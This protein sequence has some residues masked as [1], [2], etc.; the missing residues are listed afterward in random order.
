MADVI[1]IV[2]KGESGYGPIDEAYTEK[3][4]IDREAIRYEYK[5]MT[6]S[7]SVRKWSYRTNSPEFQNLFMEAA[8]AVEVILN[9]KQVPFVMD[10]G[11]TTFIITYADKTKRER[12]FFLSG[13]EF[14]D[15]YEVIKRMVP[16]CENTPGVLRTTEHYNDTK[17]S[18]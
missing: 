11:A 5:P 4:T 12:E 2:I 18:I 10:I 7:N 15:C 16:G 3:V 8:K 1:R 6:E 9:W 13:D 14:K 17:D